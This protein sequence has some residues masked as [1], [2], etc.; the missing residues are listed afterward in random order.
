MVAAEQLPRQ[1]S[2]EGHLRIAPESR[3]QQG[4]PHIRM[5]KTA[6]NAVS[7]LLPPL[8]KFQPYNIC[9]SALSCAN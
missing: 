4:L 6:Q 5:S 1:L 8:V 9:S 2:E 7:P 3:S